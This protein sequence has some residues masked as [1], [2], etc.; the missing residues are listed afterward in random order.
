[1]LF[2]F[3][4]AR[5]CDSVKVWKR[6]WKCQ[7]VKVSLLLPSWMCSFNQSICT[8]N[9]LPLIELGL[10]GKCSSVQYTMMWRCT[11]CS[12][13][14]IL[15]DISIVILVAAV[16]CSDDMS[17]QP[18]Q[19]KTARNTSKRHKHIIR[20]TKIDHLMKIPWQVPTNDNCGVFWV[21]WAIKTDGPFLILLE[22]MGWI[23]SMMETSKL[24]Y[25]SFRSNFNKKYYNVF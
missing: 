12:F 16:T 18:K 21:D 17:M 14:L 10:D 9:D 7:S 24:P 15:N 22:V 4:T 2:H 23:V 25:P 5:Q 19:H 6:A 11:P 20:S 13:L 3:D 1:M 8:D